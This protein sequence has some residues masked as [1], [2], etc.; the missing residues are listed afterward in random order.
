ML[1]LCS[2]AKEVW[3]RQ[4]MDVIIDKACEIDR[5]GEAILEYLLLLPDQDM[6]IKGTKMY[7]K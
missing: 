3:T 7:V 5:V 4:G 1:F 2:K 6:G